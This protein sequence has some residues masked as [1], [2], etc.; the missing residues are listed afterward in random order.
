MNEVHKK[1]GKIH[2]ER[3]TIGDKILLDTLCAQ[4]KELMSFQSGERDLVMLQHK[5]VVGW[6]D[7]K[8]GLSRYNRSTCMTL[9]TGLQENF[10]SKL[11]DPK[12]YSGM[13]L[14]VGVTRSIA[15]Q[16]L[17]DGHPALNKS[18]VWLLYHGNMGSD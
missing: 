13:A 15:T 2:E 17:L 4:L 1:G 12:R 8:N 5:V 3:K 16:L 9:R 11:S 7:G 6:A 10:T 18:G 14:S